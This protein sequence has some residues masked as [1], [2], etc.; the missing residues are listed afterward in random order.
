MTGFLFERGDERMRTYRL[1]IAY[2]GTAYQG[3]QIQGI[4]ESCI[5]KA[6]GYAVE[7]NGS[8]RTD[9]GVHARGQTASVVLHGK[10]EDGFF[11]EKVNKL[12]PPDIRIREA[13]LEKN[14]FHARKSAVGKRYVYQ[15]DTDE[16][17]D[18]FDRRYTY[19]FPKKLDIAAMQQAAELL[20]GTHEFA[21]YTDKKDEMSTKRTI[22]A[23]MV[24]G[25][26]GRI[27]I[28]YEGTGFL[29]HMVRILTGTLLEVGMGTRRIESV[30]IAL[31]AKD[32]TK[33]GFLAPARGLFL[34]EVYYKEKSWKEE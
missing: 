27:N 32:R 21:A 23:I 14:G 34:D 7:V 10:A 9:A 29:Y 31:E 4:L 25:Q 18:V 19:H 11:T 1:V 2:D 5:S 26:G 30:T 17:P 24:G 33:A 28:Q 22:Y 6:A 12:L 16:K 3:W 20:T 15:I 8:G 13:G